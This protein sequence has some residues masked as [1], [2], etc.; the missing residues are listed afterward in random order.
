MSKLAFT[1][2]GTCPS[3][4]ASQDVV[5]VDVRVFAQ[6]PH[7]DALSPSNFRNKCW[8]I[9]M[10]TYPG[11]AFAVDDRQAFPKPC[12]EYFVTIMPQALVK[13]RAYLPWSERVI[14]I[15]PPT[16]TVPSVH[17][18]E[19]QPVSEPQ[20]LL[21]FGP[22]IM[23][24]LGYIAHARSGDK[25]L[26]CNIGFF[27]RH[28]D[29]YA[30]LKSLLTVNRIIDI[31][32][33][34]YNG[35]RIERSELPNIHALKEMDLDNFAE[36]FTSRLKMACVVY[37]NRGLG[38]SD[39]GPGQPRQEIVPDLR[40]ADISDAIT[41]AQSRSE[42]DPERIGNCGSSY[43]GG[44][45]LHVGAVDRR[46]KVVLSQILLSS[47]K[48]I[49]RKVDR[50][51]RAAGNTPATVK[52]VD[53]NPLA[54]SALPTPD[55]YD[56]FQKL[57]APKS[58]WKNEVTLKSL[59]LF[60]AHDPSAWIHRISPTPLLMTV[61]ENDVLTPTDLALE[62]YSRAREPK[63]LS[64]LPGGHFDAYT[65]NNFERNATRQIKFLKDFL[66]V[67]DN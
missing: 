27:V 20:P 49:S 5:T 19:V 21:S 12:N 24:P 42:V 38:D 6:A 52:V 66:G 48:A 29:E 8:N 13:H 15:E 44:H 51:E 1:V 65:G 22:S 4:P 11:A 47:W 54:P 60:R 63:Q 46:V 14:D 28:E 36:R 64:M 37:D 61:A 45:V 58:A 30:W 7:A 40:V 50:L 26:D 23:A 55:S 62:A 33:N 25:G 57:W 67:E 31:L 35:G 32:Q 2:S 16:D 10:S 41:F 53:E 34:D 39:T 56:L 3:N 17:Q 43:S 59:E 18:Q 9:V